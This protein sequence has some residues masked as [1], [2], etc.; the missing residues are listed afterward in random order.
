MAED[1]VPASMRQPGCVF[2]CPGVCFHARFEGLSAY[3]VKQKVWGHCLCC[4]LSVV[5][6]PRETRREIHSLLI[7]QDSTCT[8]CCFPVLGVLPEH[9]ALHAWVRG[10][11]HSS[12]QSTYSG[13]RHPV[14]F[15][16]TW[17][18]A[19]ERS[20]NNPS[21]WNSCSRA[22]PTDSGWPVYPTECCLDD[23]V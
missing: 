14:C 12:E 11:G 18:P 3:T 4:S 17:A 6:S 7:S 16:S 21:S 9:L 19:S 1:C 15:G 13:T 8:G 20:P 2:P 5:F 23:G 10:A 22:L